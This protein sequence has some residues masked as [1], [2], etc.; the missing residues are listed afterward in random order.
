[1]MVENRLYFD[2]V[3]GL[4]VLVPTP[5]IL[6][7]FLMKKTKMELLMLNVQAVGLSGGSAKG[8]LFNKERCG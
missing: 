8:T 3:P 6:S 1:M 7:Q 4:L 5:S 2:N